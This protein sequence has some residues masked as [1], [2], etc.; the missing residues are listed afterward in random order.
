MKSLV[1]EE[2]VRTS[3]YLDKS[4]KEELD[5]LVAKQVIKNQ[6]ALINLA[7]QKA[8]AEIQREMA[9]KKLMQ[10]VKKIKRVKPSKPTEQLV[11]ELR[12]RSK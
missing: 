3:I 12:Q 8:I 11:S 6:T 5:N 10:K 7:L 1:K 2:C 4:T 9:A